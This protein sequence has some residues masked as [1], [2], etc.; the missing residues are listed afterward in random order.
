MMWCSRCQKNVSATSTRGLRYHQSSKPCQ[1]AAAEFRSHALK[2]RI[3]LREANNTESSTQGNLDSTG[4]ASQ[5]PSGAPP[6][7]I[8]VS[9]AAG[10][11]MDA[12][13]SMCFESI[14]KVI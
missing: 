8:Q 13:V 3:A 6:A 11:S 1:T 10:T 14:S 4:S 5:T 2:K 9:T 7:F 12:E